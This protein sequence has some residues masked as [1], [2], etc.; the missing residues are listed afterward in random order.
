MLDQ[1][2]PIILTYNEEA[3]IR[4][5]LQSVRW[6]KKV[7]VVDSYSTDSTLEICAKHSNVQIVQRKFDDFANQC[8]FALE[9]DI[10]TEWVLSMDA[11]YIISD[12][13]C[14]EILSI[15]P[16]PNTKAF[17]I[18]FE[19]LIDGKKLRA[20]LY[21]PRVALYRIKTAHYHQDGHA[22]KVMIEGENIEQSLSSPIERLNAKILHDDRKPY[23]RWLSSQSNYATQEANKLNNLSWKELSPQ[24]ISRKLGIAP[25]LVIPYTLFVRGLILDGWLGLK[26]TYQRF[27]AEHM[28]QIARFKKLFN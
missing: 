24:D 22:H 7:L 21:P 4:R 27:I 14:S 10:K 2:T 8:N 23:S 15:N 19:Y 13:L 11:D 17:Q 16:S 9:Q 12:G 1:I 5:T 28:L 18:S 3:N 25:I 20:S 26:Y 6:A